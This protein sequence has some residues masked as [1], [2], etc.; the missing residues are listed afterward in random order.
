MNQQ[1]IR[2]LLIAGVA[3][4]FSCWEIWSA[5]ARGTVHFPGFPVRTVER[6]RQPIMFWGQVGLYAR[7]VAA[8]ACAV[9]LVLTRSIAH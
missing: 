5:F 6:I 4:P 2:V 8:S 3:I 1:V 9:L 7:L